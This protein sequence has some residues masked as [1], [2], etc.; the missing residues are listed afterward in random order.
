MELEEGEW[1]WL[2]PH[3]QRNALFVVANSLSL[4]EVGKAIASDSSLQVQKWIQENQLARPSSDQIAMWEAVPQT[5]FSFVI[6][7]PYVLV[8]EKNELPS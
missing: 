4:V 2:K 6:V 3:Y 7:Q 1:S 5:R 8:Q